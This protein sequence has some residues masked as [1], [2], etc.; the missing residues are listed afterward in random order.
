MK[1]EGLLFKTYVVWFVVAG[2][3]LSTAGA[4]ERSVTSLDEGWR[5]I[6]QDVINAGQAGFDDASWQSVSLPHTWNNLDGQ[7]GGGNYYRGPGWY[8]RHLKLDP[9]LSGHRLYLYFEAAS[10]AAE[11][12]VKRRDAGGRCLL[13]V[14]VRNPSDKIALM[15]HLQLRRKSTGERVL[16]VY[17]S[18]NYISLVPQESRTVTIE[19]AASD[20]KG[21]KPFLVLDGWNIDMTPVASGDCEVALNKNA[22]VAS[23]PVTNI[24]VKK[25]DPIGQIKGVR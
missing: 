13:D 22:Q 11:V 24:S 14:A 8:R 9:A 19:A 2:L 16:P 18:D 12:L 7:D 23:W 4:M 10:Q 17:Y 5:F 15:A 6:R 21:D 3:T 1:R 25:S 20:L